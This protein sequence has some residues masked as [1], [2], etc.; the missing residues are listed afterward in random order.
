VSD[1]DQRRARRGARGSCVGARLEHDLQKLR[2]RVDPPDLSKAKHRFVKG[3]I[4]LDINRA[5]RGPPTLTG[6]VVGSAAADDASSI[7]AAAITVPSFITRSR[8]STLPQLSFVTL[9]DPGVQAA[10]RGDRATR[11]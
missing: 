1:D 10:R 2:S 4:S 6:G 3:G 7:A 11:P 5:N 8:L 9:K